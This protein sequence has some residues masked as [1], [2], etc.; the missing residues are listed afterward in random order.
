MF[1]YEVGNKALCRIFIPLFV[2]DGLVKKIGSGSS[3]GGCGE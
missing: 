1:L 3:D 2:E